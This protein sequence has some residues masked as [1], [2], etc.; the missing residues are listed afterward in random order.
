MTGS[1]A[2]SKPR[3][4]SCPSSTIGFPLRPS[5]YWSSLP[6][7]R[8]GPMPPCICLC[9]WAQLQWHRRPKVPRSCWPCILT[10]SPTSSSPCRA[11]PPPLRRRKCP[12]LGSNPSMC[13]SCR[14]RDIRLYS[15]C[16]T[17]LKGGS[18]SAWRRWNRP[19]AW[20]RQSSKGRARCGLY[21]CP[22]GWRGDASAG[23]SL[24]HDYL[25]P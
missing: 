6:A 7:T 13:S 14:R 4:S 1:I 3:R 25:S 16:L 21:F 18:L 17:S 23:Y 12:Y 2:S 5:F 22:M 19:S 15:Q 8:F 20:R 24:D 9:L 11:P 10:A